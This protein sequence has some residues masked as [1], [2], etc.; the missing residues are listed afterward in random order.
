MARF[1]RVAE[2]ARAKVALTIDGVACTALA[3]DTVLTALLVNGARVRDSEFGD[4]TRAGFCLMGACQDCWVCDVRVR[5][6]RGEVAVRDGTDGESVRFRACSTPVEDG[7]AIV[8]IAPPTSWIG[9]T[10]E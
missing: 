8:T 10:S 6:V 7:M 3:G 4:G 9:G 5:D 1:V 2:K